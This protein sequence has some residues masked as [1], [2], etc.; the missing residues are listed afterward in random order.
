MDCYTLHTVLLLIILL[1]ILAIICSHCAK[2]RLKRKNIGTL[3]VQ[4]WR[5]MNQKNFV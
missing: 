1:F 2:H 4:K 5:I 3:T